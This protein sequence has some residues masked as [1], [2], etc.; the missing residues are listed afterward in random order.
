MQTTG[1][2]EARSD[3]Q[4]CRRIMIAGG[5]DDRGTGGRNRGKAVV[6]DADGVGRGHRP[7]EDVARHHD[8]ID[9]FRGDDVCEVTQRRAL[10]IEQVGAVEGSADMPVG[11]V[12]DSHGKHRTICHRQIRGGASARPGCRH[13]APA[14]STAPSAAAAALASAAG[15]YERCVAGRLRNSVA[16]TPISNAAA[17]R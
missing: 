17:G 4:T 7:V 12:Q 13:A 2:G 10:V 5:H 11:G 6:V 1:C 3:T 16:T 15:G 14:S 8:D 9:R